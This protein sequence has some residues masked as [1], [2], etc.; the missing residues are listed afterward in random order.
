MPRPLLSCPKPKKSLQRK[1]RKKK[2]KE[3]KERKKERKK[4]KKEKNH[5]PLSMQS[6]SPKLSAQI[7]KALEEKGYLYYQVMSREKVDMVV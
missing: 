7:F 5:P 4:R 1:K 6:V 3:K 2:K